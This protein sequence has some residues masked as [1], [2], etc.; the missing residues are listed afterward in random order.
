MTKVA[1]AINDW[2]R[3]LL[4]TRSEIVPAVRPRKN[5]GACRMPTARPTMNGESVNSRITQPRTTF[6]PRVILS[7]KDAEVSNLKSRNFKTGEFLI[8]FTKLVIKWEQIIFQ[9]SSD[10]QMYPH[11]PCRRH[12]Y[13]SCFH[14]WLETSL[15][16]RLPLVPH[17]V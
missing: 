13:R 14:R 5:A 16:F 7:K 8:L 11:Q 17:I 3:V 15:V 9:R 10:L 12:H 6:S 2:M 4:S 1:V